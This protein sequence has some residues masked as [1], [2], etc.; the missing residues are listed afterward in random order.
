MCPGCRGP[1]SRGG[2]C[3]SRLHFGGSNFHA[4]LE[5]YTPRKVE[6]DW[7][8]STEILALTA[9]TLPELTGRSWLKVPTKWNDV[10][11]CMRR[12]IASDILAGGILS[13]AFRGSSRPHRSA[14]AHCF[15]ERR[16]P[17]FVGEAITVD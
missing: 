6:P 7:D 16:N 12:G 1:G 3:L 9:E 13:I 4:V 5:E 2:P 10:R 8:G 15:G 17:R 14:T 11:D